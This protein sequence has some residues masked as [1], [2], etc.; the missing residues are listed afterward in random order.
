MERISAFIK[1]ALIVAV[2]C[3]ITLFIVEPLSE[4]FYLT[5]ISLIVCLIVII[6]GAIYIRKRKE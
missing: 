5:I 1:L 3:V 6:V 4:G 2:I